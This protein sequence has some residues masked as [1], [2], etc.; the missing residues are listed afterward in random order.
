MSVDETIFA[1]LIEL[2]IPY[3][4]ARHQKLHTIEEC[5]Q[6]EQL[7]NAKM[8]KN[9]LLTTTNHSAYALLVM[10][11]DTPFKT[12]IVSKNAGYS[13]LSFA[14]NDDVERLLRAY[15]GSVSPFG[16]MFDEDKR[17]ECLIDRKLLTEECLLF[18]PLDNSCS[19]KIRT[20]DLLE[21]FLPSTGHKA[22]IIETIIMQ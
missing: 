19:V 8:P 18:H 4:L 17:V 16:L 2:G 22:R 5:A 21:V 12:G 6:A 15:S 10:D 13:R 7:L 20:R 11:G 9:L 14:S 3:E 1:K